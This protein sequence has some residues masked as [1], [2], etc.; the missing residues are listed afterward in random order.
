MEY[1]QRCFAGVIGVALYIFQRNLLTFELTADDDECSDY[2][3]NEINQELKSAK[4]CIPI[5]KGK[6]QKIESRDGKRKNYREELKLIEILKTLRFALQE[7]LDAI[8]AYVQNINKCRNTIGKNRKKKIKCDP[9][10]SSLI[11][12]TYSLICAK[13]KTCLNDITS[14]IISASDL[15]IKSLSVMIEN[16]IKNAYKGIAPTAY[17]NLPEYVSM[18]TC[19]NL[20]RDIF[21]SSVDVLY[22]KLSHFYNTGRKLSFKS[23][24]FLKLIAEVESESQ[25]EKYVLY[26]A[27]SL[28]DEFLPS[29][30]IVEGLIEKFSA[31][32]ES[33][34]DR[35]HDLESEFKG[36][37]ELALSL[38]KL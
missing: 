4:I 30:I 21:K 35:I 14:L 33:F 1:G 12:D 34:A 29:Y 28:I 32:D 38:V 19:E 7:P 17:N 9:G 37:S 22:S 2:K 16:E 15:R 5:K 3:K 13:F 18:I 11:P 31:Q 36:N 27:Y 20:I 23:E 24:K 10:Y 26:E 8:S 25:L 6:A